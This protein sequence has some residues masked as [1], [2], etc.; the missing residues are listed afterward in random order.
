MATLSLM[1][2]TFTIQRCIIRDMRKLDLLGKRF[3]RLTVIARAPR[4]GEKNRWLCRCDCGKTSVAH[5]YDL[6]HGKHR[7][8]GCLLREVVKE[9]FTT[10]GASRGMTGY[11]GRATNASEYHAWLA[12]RQRCR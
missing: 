11:G 5:V 10:H 7:S 2:D 1:S 6:T 3:G 8:C 12:I 9:L 4:Q